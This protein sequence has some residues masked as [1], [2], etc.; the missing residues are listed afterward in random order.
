MKLQKSANVNWKNTDDGEGGS[1]ALM[2]ASK[3]GHAE[4]IRSNNDGDTGQGFAQVK[5]L[6]EQNQHSNR[7]GP[8]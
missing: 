4:A 7:L 3:R 5:L 8:R 1:T 2:V 6:Q